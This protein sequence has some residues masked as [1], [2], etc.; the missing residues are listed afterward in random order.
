MPQWKSLPIKLQ[1]ASKVWNHMWTELVCVCAVLVFDIECFFVLCFFGPFVLLWS[2]TMCPCI[3]PPF[4]WVMAIVHSELF[5]VGCFRVSD[6]PKNLLMDTRRFGYQKDIWTT[7]AYSAIP[8]KP[9]WST[10]AGKFAFW[11]FGSESHLHSPS[12]TFTNAAWQTCTS[13]ARLLI[14]TLNVEFASTNI[15]FQFQQFWTWQLGDNA[16]S[17]CSCGVNGVHIASP[18]PLNLFVLNHTWLIVFF[19]LLNNI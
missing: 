13:T 18:V 12:R 5:A 3:D 19:I 2:R 9:I 11:L 8:S 14:V 6:R 17:A 10:S 1:N 16:L 7:R 4:Q 15:W